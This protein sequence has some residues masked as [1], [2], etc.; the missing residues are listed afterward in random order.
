MDLSDCV[1]WSHPVLSSTIYIQRSIGQFLAARALECSKWT[2]ASE[3]GGVFLGSLL[4]GSPEPSILITQAKLV[5]SEGPLCNHSALDLQNLKNL[6]RQ[7]AQD[8]ES[9]VIGYFRSHIRDGLRLS[10]WDRQL[11]E[12]EIRDAHCIFLTLRPLE[13]GVNMA[14][15]CFWQNG[16]L[17]RDCTELEVPFFITDPNVKR[18]SMGRNGAPTDGQPATS[19]ESLWTEP[20]AERFPPKAPS[21]EVRFPETAPGSAEAASVE[22]SVKPSP[23]EP[24]IPK[25]VQVEGVLPETSLNE[26]TSTDTL[27]EA[28]PVPEAGLAEPVPVERG[29]REDIPPVGVDAPP[30]VDHSDNQFVGPGLKVKAKDS[31]HEEFLVIPVENGGG[32]LVSVRRTANLSTAPK[33]ALEKKHNEPAFIQLPSGPPPLEPLSGEKFVLATKKFPFV[34]ASTVVLAIIMAIGAYFALRSLRPQ[35]EIQTLSGVDLGLRLTRSDEGRLNLKWSPDVLQKLSAQS[36]KLSITDGQTQRTFELDKGQLRSGSITYFPATGDV[37]FSLDVYLEGSQLVSQSMRVLRPGFSASN[38]SHL[39]KPEPSEAGASKAFIA[40]EKQSA[41]PALILPASGNE[42]V[43]APSNQVEPLRPEPLPAPPP[44]LADSEI[45]PSSPLPQALTAINQKIPPMRDD[46]PPAVARIANVT[47]RP[48]HTSPA[49]APKEAADDMPSIRRQVLQPRDPGAQVQLGAFSDMSAMIV[50][51]VHQQPAAQPAGPV[52]ETHAAEAVPAP[53]TAGSS[54][55]D[56]APRPLKQVLP[57]LASLPELSSDFD[58]NILTQIDESGRVVDARVMSSTGSPG[59][60][61]VEQSIRAAK[62]W[63]FAPA[64]SNGHNIPGAYV[65]QFHLRK[66]E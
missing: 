13:T 60:A 64:S 49:P 61:V 37:K 14:S 16:R 31:S 38:S 2:P 27:V 28:A 40:L 46:A 21:T 44:N 66:S 4:P 36:G 9:Q 43:S 12:Q 34:F 47:T 41:R 53:S 50:A 7:C 8:G 56:I 57:D 62:Q 55:G 11:I 65:I 48:L 6:V 24:V 3:I 10:Y 19:A 54:N 25:P 58:I 52:P 35:Q 39:P 22:R 30:R 5:N 45:L 63:L 20:V 15:S 42:P 23:L 1:S 59:P 17:E 33:S 32:K 18:I 26:A 51:R 29:R